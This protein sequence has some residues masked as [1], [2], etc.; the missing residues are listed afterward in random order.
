[1]ETQ[2]ILQHDYIHCNG[3]TGNTN[4]NSLHIYN[5]H[6]RKLSFSMLSG[7]SHKEE[8]YTFLSTKYRPIETFYT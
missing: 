1:M 5:K 6:Y 8:V 3:N 7:I 4:K 2:F